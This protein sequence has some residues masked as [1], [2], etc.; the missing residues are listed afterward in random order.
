MINLLKKFRNLEKKD[1]T[2]YDYFYGLFR[3]LK[4]T[5][6]KYYNFKDDYYVID[7]ANDQRNLLIILAGKKEFLWDLVFPRIY[8]NVDSNVDVVIVNPGDI[9][10]QKLRN[11]AKEYNFSYLATKSRRISTALNIAIRDHKNA[12][13]I[14][15]VD[16]DIFLTGNF[17]KKLK[18]TYKNIERNEIWSPGMVIP[19]QNINNYT[20]YLFLNTLGLKEKFTE[21]FGRIRVGTNSSIIKSNGKAAIWIWKNSLPLN[22]VSETFNRKNK[23]MGDVCP[24]R[25]SINAALIK[26]DLWI[27]MGGFDTSFPGQLEADEISLNRQILIFDILQIVVSL[28]TF[29]GHFSYASQENAVKKFFDKNKHLFREN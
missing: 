25:C 2:I 11:I 24:L 7:R 26:R 1:Y 16:D 22:I 10:S 14:Y 8:S 12:K 4:S 20:Y 27:R 29:V 17:L 13:W 28:D 15:K 3:F 9:N 19:V 18:N 23:N 21:I 5:Y 6:Q